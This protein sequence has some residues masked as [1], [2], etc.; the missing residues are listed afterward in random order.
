V[1][2]RAAYKQGEFHDVRRTA[3]T[4]WLDDR[5][6]EHEVM[7]LAGHASFSTTHRFYLAAADD[8]VDRA[9]K[10]VG[11]VL[12]PCGITINDCQITTYEIRRRSAEGQP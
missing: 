5:I 3:L 4:N 1:T 10:A 12:S 7:L 8:L 6:S 9:R 2:N 11:K